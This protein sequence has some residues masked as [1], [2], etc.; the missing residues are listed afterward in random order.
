VALC[1]CGVASASEGNIVQAK[2]A[3]AAT[4]AARGSIPPPPRGSALGARP[5]FKRSYPAPHAH[6]GC[7][8]QRRLQDDRVRCR[9]FTA[10]P[11]EAGSVNSSRRLSPL[12]ALLTPRLS[13][14]PEAPDW[15]RGCRLSSRT[16][17]DTTELHGPLQAVVRGTAAVLP[18]RPGHL[19]LTHRAHA[20]NSHLE[21]S[22]AF[23]EATS[24]ECSPSRSGAT[25]A[26]YP[27]SLH[28]RW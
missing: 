5:A 1:A 22:Q 14:R 28:A 4:E 19:A 9:R 25:L 27:C 8:K 26:P 15:S 20:R 7:A 2:R 17:G 3:Q 6:A 13:G 10:E 18:R 11:N 12:S 21:R 23:N 16:R 24:A